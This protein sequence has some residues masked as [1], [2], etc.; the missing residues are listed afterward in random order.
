LSERYK[1]LLSEIF[2]HKGLPKDFSLYLHMPTI[3][4]PSMAPAGS[5]SFYVLS[6]V[7]HLGADID[8]TVQARPYRDAIMN[9]LE[10]NYLPDLQANIVAEH[11][12]DPLHFEGTLNS[13]LG[14]AFSV[15]PILTQSAWFRPHNRSE[16]F[17]NLYFVGAGTHPGAGVPGVL[18]SGK[19][20]DALIGSAEQMHLAVYNSQHEPER[21]LA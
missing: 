15:Q 12:I 10:E 11:Y 1:G 19:I 3:T 14:S 18:S 5:E 9:F 20:V 8:W 13:Y 7:P 2:G 4:D 21:L 17:E 6:P 16:D